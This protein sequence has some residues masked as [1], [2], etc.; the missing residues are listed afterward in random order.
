MSTQQF[1][2]GRS[3]SLRYKLWPRV[4]RALVPLGLFA[5][6]TA[7]NRPEACEY[8]CTAEQ[9][10]CPDGLTCDVTLGYCVSE[11]YT[12]TCDAETHDV[13]VCKGEPVV[14]ELPADAPSSPTEIQ[15][16][17]AS[18]EVQ[19][20]KLKAQFSR[21]TVFAFGAP[22]QARRYWQV[23]VSDDCPVL[24]TT[25]APLCVGDSLSRALNVRGGRGDVAFELLESDAD[26]TLSSDGILAGKAAT[27]GE[28]QLKVGVTDERGLT[29]VRSVTVA[30]SSECPNLAHEVP[31]SCAGS[32]YEVE[33]GIVGKAP[34]RVTDFTPIKKDGKDLTSTQ[35]KD[36][37]AKLGLDVVQRD[38]DYLLTAA[39][40]VEALGSYVLALKLENALSIEQLN[41]PFGVKTCSAVRADF[42]ECEGHRLDF[43]LRGSPGDV[44][45]FYDDQ[46]PLSG[47]LSFVSDR[48]LRGDLTAP[49][50]YEVRARVQNATEKTDRLVTL[51]LAILANSHPACSPGDDGG[52]DAGAQSPASESQESTTTEADAGSH[53]PTPDLELATGCVA[54][55]YQFAI[56]AEGIQAGTWQAIGALPE[57]LSLDEEGVLRGVPTAPF[58]GQIDVGGLRGSSIVTRTYNLTIHEWCSVVFRGLPGSSTKARLYLADRREEVATVELSNAL[59]ASYEVTAFAV[60]PDRLHVA[61][62]A[63]SSNDGSSTLIVRR[64]VDLAP[65]ATDSIFTGPIQSAAFDGTITEINWDKPTR[66]TF[67]LSGA[68]ANGPT[69]AA[70]VFAI[71]KAN[72]VTAPTQLLSK[73][74]TDARDLTWADD[75]P[76]ISLAELPASPNW[77]TLCFDVG[78]GDTV[79]G[80]NVSIHLDQ[81]QVRNHEGRFLQVQPRGGGLVV[82]TSWYPFPTAGV[83][84]ER[85]HGAR[86]ASPR[87]DLVATI[88]N[89]DLEIALASDP[90]IYDPADYIAVG[91]P[92][93]YVPVG[94]VVGCTSVD[95]WAAGGPLACSNGTDATVTVALPSSN[96]VTVKA[97]FQA[98]SHAVSGQRTFVGETY[99]LFD[100]LAGKLNYVDLDASPPTVAKHTLPDGSYAIAMQ[101]IS[102]NRFVLQGREALWVGTLSHGSPV[103]LVAL[104]SAPSPATFSECEPHFGENAFSHWCGGDLAPARFQ[105]VPGGDLGAY[106]TEDNELALFSAVAERLLKTVDGIR[107]TC[108]D[109][110]YCRT[111]FAITR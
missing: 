56:P 104:A 11:D 17:P 61:F 53:S 78:T 84:E 111:A 21:K 29:T 75:Y 67:L 12:G 71:N 87:G 109:H 43:D 58:V 6:V 105:V 18:A 76:C 33:L 26:F 22:N 25:L 106:Q 14:L 45:R 94:T 68:D 5:L 8:R 93:P 100:D 82:I 23:A 4:R 46:D 27:A 73:S 36:F 3:L 79:E 40:R 103:Q 37:V 88:R 95:A 10:A 110:P 55:P 80:P 34:I 74:V 15:G 60:S 19:D 89:Q 91:Q 38:D 83:V 66:V 16:L 99:Y 107:V 65:G 28:H 47:P 101:P 20:G 51:Q 50:S 97:A 9:D 70:Y 57:G 108:G 92:P 98:S 54:E 49:G 1:V 30:V 35:A 102:A 90:T 39:P 64:L 24:E 31:D 44:W 96:G 42:T 69:Q 32:G 86:F 13:V 81:Y 72:G 52:V 7:C 48:R 77:G 41:V 2:T 85:L 62:A 59:D 63:R